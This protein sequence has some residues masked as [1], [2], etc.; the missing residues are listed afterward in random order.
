MASGSI[1]GLETF[2]L[3][4][5]VRHQVQSC[6]FKQSFKVEQKKEVVNQ[7][8]Q[9]NEVGTMHG[10]LTCSSHTGVSEGNNWILEVIKRM[11]VIFF[12]LLDEGDGLRLCQRP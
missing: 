7:R 12:P 5:K 1:T 8:R 9:V 4:Y 3:D 10:T 11:V 6:I 2:T